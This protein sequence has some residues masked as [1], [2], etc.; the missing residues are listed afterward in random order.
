MEEGRAFALDGAGAGGALAKGP[1]IRL[2]P[3]SSEWVLAFVAAD[4]NASWPFS[5]NS[6]CC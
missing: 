2:D 6:L 3:D 1:A 5:L 4:P